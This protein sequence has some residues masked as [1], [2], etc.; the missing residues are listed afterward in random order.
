MCLKLHPDRT[1]TNDCKKFQAMQKAYE[2]LMNPTKRAKYD[3]DGT[4]DEKQA[5]FIV[6][7]EILDKCRE[8]Y[9]GSQFHLKILDFQY[10]ILLSSK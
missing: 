9:A 10:S 7:D 6:T 2:V 3:A 5:I 8:N 1:Q 4:V